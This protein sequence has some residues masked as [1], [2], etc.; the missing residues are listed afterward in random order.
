M[1]FDDPQFSLPVVLPIV[2][3]E[4]GGSVA[5]T[6]GF[7]PASVGPHSA[8]ATLI[9]EDPTPGTFSLSGAGLANEAP[10]LG[11]CDIV[12]S[13]VLLGQAPTF[14]LDVSDSATLANIS[15]CTAFG[16]RIAGGPTSFVLLDLVDD[17]STVGDIACDG[18]RTRTQQ[19]G[20]LFGRGTWEFDLECTDKQGNASSV[21]TCPTQLEIQ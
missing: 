4:L 11:A 6:L 5:V 7:L 16:T 10:V 15:Q 1:I 14:T 9:S 2:I 3:P 13:T 17:G 18:T 20:G 12:P 8:T 21:L 19:T